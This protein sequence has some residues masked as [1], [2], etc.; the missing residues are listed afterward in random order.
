MG[1]AR[2][3]AKA[4]PVCRRRAGM[5]LTFNCCEIL[6]IISIGDQSHCVPDISGKRFAYIA[7][8]PG[9]VNTARLHDFTVRSSIQELPFELEDHE[10]TLH[11]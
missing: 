4:R 2:R 5:A 8:V 10:E 7:S 11:R 3:C 9:V 6:F 1:K